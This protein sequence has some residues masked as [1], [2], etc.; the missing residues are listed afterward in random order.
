MGY[1]WDWS[2]IWEYRYAFLRGAEW[3]LVLSLIS[4]IIGTSVGVGW[5]T[6]LSAKS[7]ALRPVSLFAT[8]VGDLVRALPLLVLLLFVNYYVPPI[9]GIHSTFWICITAL[10]LN[11]AAF[12]ADVIRGAISGVPRPLIEGALAVGMT[13]RQAMRRIIL[14]EALRN[15]IPA[16]TLLYIDILK[17]SS[18][19]SVIGYPELANIGGQISARTFRPLEVIAAVALIYIV[20]VLPLTWGQRKLELSPWFMRRS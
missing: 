8:F 5:G 3:T 1:D 18:L 2:I 9:V 4:I 13:D 15:V 10:S 6:L 20:I 14:P 12:L 7:Q 16:F 17:M 11:L 19:A